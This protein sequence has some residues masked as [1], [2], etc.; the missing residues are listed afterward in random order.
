MNTF[1]KDYDIFAVGIANISFEF[2]G[3]KIEEL[4][5]KLFAAHSVSGL[6]LETETYSVNVLGYFDEDLNDS[7]PDCAINERFVASCNGDQV[8]IRYQILS[9]DNSNIEHE[10]VIFEVEQDSPSIN[11]SELTDTA[12]DIETFDINPTALVTAIGAYSFGQESEA[13]DSF[14]VR[15]DWED[16]MKRYP[17]F[18]LSQETISWWG[19]QSTEAR[20][21][22]KGDVKIEEALQMFA[23]W[24]PKGTYAWG[25]GKEFDISIL[26]HAFKVTGIS[27]PWAYYNTCDMR[28]IVRIG[29]K[30]G[31]DPKRVLPFTGTKHKSIDDATHEGKVIKSLLNA[32]A[33]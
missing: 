15:I 24:Y 26:D 16:A 19:K 31:I 7:E 20:E 10:S 28:T 14:H 22:L 5:K 29:R 12:V 13:S 11:E 17:E 21:E 1:T 8:K 33:A 3:K 32:I 30:H 9:L 27:A 4:A 25:N 2:D 23:D 18:T 6:K